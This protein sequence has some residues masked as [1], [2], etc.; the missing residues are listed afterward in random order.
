MWQAPT[1][2]SKRGEIVDRIST[3]IIFQSM[4]ERHDRVAV[5]MIFARGG[6]VVV[7]PN[8]WD[9]N[10]TG[11]QCLYGDD[12]ATYQVPGGCWKP[13]CDPSHP[14]RSQSKD[15]SLCGFGGNDKVRNAWRP[16]DLSTMLAL[17]G[18]HSQP[19]RAPSWFSGYNE[20]VWSSKEW[21]AHLP[22]TIEAFFLIANQEEQYYSTIGVVARAHEDFARHYRTRDVPL[23]AFDPTN[24]NCPFSAALPEP[25]DKRECSHFCNAWTTQ[26][27]Q[28]RNCV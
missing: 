19:Y 17:Y 5:P 4:R 9:G 10:L 21:N 22:S 8:V 1:K 28:C 13:F 16:E 2:D 25:I 7:S 23:L 27:A 15:G 11:L 14:E 3:M 24:F 18:V 20:L 26:D 6:G 12:G